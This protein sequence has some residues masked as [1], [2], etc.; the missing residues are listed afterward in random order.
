MHQAQLDRRQ[1]IEDM[2]DCNDDAYS[3]YRRESTGSLQAVESNPLSR[4]RREME[5]AVATE[6]YELAARL[7]N[8]I[9]KI[10]QRPL[11]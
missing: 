8:E 3:A 11:G 2:R 5:R 9:R 7:R 1:Q 10:E 4:L 6:D